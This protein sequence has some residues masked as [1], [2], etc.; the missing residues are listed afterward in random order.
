MVRLPFPGNIPFGTVRASASEEPDT[1]KEYRVIFKAFRRF[2]LHYENSAERLDMIEDIITLRASFLIDRALAGL[3][4]DLD[5][6]LDILRNHNSFT[7][8]RERQQRDILLAAIDNLIDFAAAEEYAMLREMPETVDEQ[9]ME[10]YGKICRRYNLVY[11]G[12]ENSEVLFAASIAAWWLTVDTESIITYMTQGD[13]RVRPWHLSLEGLSFRKSEFPPELIPPI[14]WGCRCYLV[15]DGF[16]AVQVALHDK[17]NDRKETDPV[18]QESLATGG[19]IFSD[20]H[21]YFSVP[22]PGYINDMVKRIKRKFAYV[23][24]NT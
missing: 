5:R 20:A 23:Q 8:V 24:D 7:T 12:R 3:R 2:I 13:E 10:A 22:L 6:A 1:E 14:E 21:P 15:A 9:D 18:F 19:R 17:A 11:A 16:A 4:I